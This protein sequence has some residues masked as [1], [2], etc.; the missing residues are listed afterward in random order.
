MVAEPPKLTSLN[1]ES[2]TD[3]IH[4]IVTASPPESPLGQ[5]SYVL[6]VLR[7][8]EE[9]EH[10]YLRRPYGLVRRPPHFMRCTSRMRGRKPG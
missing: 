2:L 8:F 10:A 3:F 9:H 1:S 5:L 6:K 4:G 7:K